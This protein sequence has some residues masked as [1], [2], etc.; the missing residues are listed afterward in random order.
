[1]SRASKPARLM[2]KASEALQSGE[3]F[4]CIELAS[5]ALRGAHAGGDFSLM[6]RVLMPL[7][8]A[9]RQVRLEAI[10]S[11]NL[12]VVDSVEQLEGLEMASGCYLFEPMLVG[13]DGR[14]WRERAEREHVAVV[15]VVHEPETDSGDWPLVMV[16]P[17]TVR[18][19]VAPPDE[20]TLEWIV[21]ANEALGD[22]AI[23]ICQDARD[24]RE[25]LDE[26]Y[27]SLQTLPDH[28]GL[29]QALHDV[30]ESMMRQ[31]ADAS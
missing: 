4:E 31:R 13:A 6:A 24:E 8:E 9:R 25:Q 2:E 26:L 15:V 7:E 1:M 29:H 14:A 10:D 19:R 30:C 20:V 3:Y 17:V 16:G 18:A 11:G 5:E 22:E 23:E 21:A 12:V 27:A 28:D